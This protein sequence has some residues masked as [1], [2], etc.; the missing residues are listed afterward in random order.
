MDKNIARLLQDLADT[1]ASAADTARSAMLSAKEAVSEKYDSVKLEFALS[2]A[3]SEQEDVFSDIG[4]MLFLMHS[5]KVQDTVATDEG[6]KSPQQVIDSLL[7]EAEQLQQQIDLFEQRLAYNDD[8][9]DDE[10]LDTVVCPKCGN[11]CVEGDCYCCA[12]GARL[13]PQPETAPAQE[14]AES[15]APAQEEP[16]TPHE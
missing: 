11:V 14:A 15:A 3:E 10:T 13:A 6:D 12:C 9:E 16:E 2:R 5:G 4:R 7:L 1:A 8:D